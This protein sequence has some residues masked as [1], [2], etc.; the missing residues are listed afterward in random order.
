[1][2]AYMEVEAYIYEEGVGDSRIAVRQDVDGLGLVEIA[3]QEVGD[4][5]YQDWAGTAVVSLTKECVPLLLQAIA[6][7]ARQV[8]K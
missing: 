1:M 6:L 2:S 7:V 8:E 3:Y 4:A 5:G